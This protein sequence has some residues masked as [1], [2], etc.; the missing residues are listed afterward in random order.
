MVSVAKNVP[1]SQFPAVP[2]LSCR[3]AY[4]KLH[5]TSRPGHSSVSCYCSV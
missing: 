5:R 4:P 2:H 3:P 1:N